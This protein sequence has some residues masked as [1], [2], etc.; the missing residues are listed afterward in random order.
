MG[1][2]A[3]AHQHQRYRRVTGHVQMREGR[4]RWS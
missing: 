1:D 4:Q 2:G 3:P